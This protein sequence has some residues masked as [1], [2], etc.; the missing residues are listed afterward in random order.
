MYTD[1]IKRT[2]S[3]LINEII[4]IRRDIHRNPELGFH[5]CRTSAIV[6]DFLKNL[7]FKVYTNIAKTGVV[8]VL[9]GKNPGKTIAIRADMDALPIAEE[10]DFEYAS[11]IKNVMHAC[12]HDAHTAIALGAAKIL[13]GFRDKISGNVKFIFQP[14]EEGLGGAALMID[15]GVLENPSADAI[16]ALHVSPLL[17]S[18]EI[19][20]GTGPVM[21]SPAEFDIAIYGKGGHAAQPNKS[22]NP[23]SIG[24]SIINMFSSIIPKTISPF[25]SAVLSVTSFEAGNTYNVIPSQAVIKGTVRAFDRETHNKI[26]NKM[27]SVVASLTSLEGADFSFDYNLGYPPV[28][29]NGEIAKLIA[30]ASKKIIGEGNVKENPEPS[31][32]AEDFSYYALK[33]PGAIFNLGCGNPCDESFENL[34]SARFKLDESCISIGMEILSQCVLD[35]LR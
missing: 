23:I 27:H 5:E 30:N 3:T 4:S 6:S 12:G 29:N 20:I 22:V 15:E 2:S 17:K 16:I 24:V 35:F 25:E 11:Q 7:G 19:S 9:E 14:A 13:S 33:V 21:A 32:L 28:I 1:E 8:G 34:H 26:Y 10:N 31:M 18:G